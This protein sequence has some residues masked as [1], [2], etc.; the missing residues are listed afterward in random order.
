MA[1]RLVFIDIR[2]M[3]THILVASCYLV[4]FICIEL[5]WRDKDVGRNIIIYEYFKAYLLFCLLVIAEGSILLS[6]RGLRRQGATYSVGLCAWY[7]DASGCTESIAE[8]FACYVFC[9]PW[10]QALVRQRG[11]IKNKQNMFRSFVQNK[12]KFS[13]FLFVCMFWWTFLE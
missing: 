9:T 8:Y 4:Y 5:I 11:K 2:F 3:I 13:Y 10:L 7:P 6:F 1:L 12:K